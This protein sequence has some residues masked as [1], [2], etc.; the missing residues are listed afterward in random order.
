MNIYRIYIL[1]LDLFYFTPLLMIDKK[2]EKDFEFIYAY[3]SVCIYWIYASYVL[4]NG[5]NIFES[6][7]KK[8]EKFSLEKELLVYAC[9]SHLVDAYIFV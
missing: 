5:E 8:G 1:I 2:G 3:L 7:Y 6:L 9:Y 4:Q